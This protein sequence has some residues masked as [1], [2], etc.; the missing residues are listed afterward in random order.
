[1]PTEPQKTNEQQ[2]P[3]ET[4]SERDSRLLR[5]IQATLRQIT[6]HLGI[7]KKPSR[8]ISPGDIHVSSHDPDGLGPAPRLKDS[9]F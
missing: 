9:D 8:P 6:D 4:P 7:T 3:D 5:E 2:K 1:M